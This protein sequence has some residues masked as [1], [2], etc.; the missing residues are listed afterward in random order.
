M[1]GVVGVDRPAVAGSRESHRKKLRRFLSVEVIA[2]IA[3]IAGHGAPRSRA[4]DQAVLAAGN[5]ASC[6]FAN[7]R[8]SLIHRRES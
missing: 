3:A 4:F 6:R 2:R 5:C 8:V 1:V 7:C